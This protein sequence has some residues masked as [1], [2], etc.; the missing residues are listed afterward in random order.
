MVQSG[1]LVPRSQV[2][3]QIEILNWRYTIW[4]CG[5]RTQKYEKKNTKRVLEQI[6]HL[7]ILKL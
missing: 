1:N 4:N 6:E 3:V 2:A 5:A 7:R